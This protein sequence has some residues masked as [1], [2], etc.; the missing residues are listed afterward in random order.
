MR[1]AKMAMYEARY[2]PEG[3]TNER[4]SGWGCQAYAVWP[5]VGGDEIQYGEHA[6]S[7]HTRH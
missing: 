2:L 5:D 4:A 3:K 7:Y 6:G 1:E